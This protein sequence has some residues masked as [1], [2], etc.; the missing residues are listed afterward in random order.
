MHVTFLHV[1]TKHSECNNYVLWLT[2]EGGGG[3]VRRGGNLCGFED[4][5]IGWLC[6]LQ[7]RKQQER[8]KSLH[9]RELI[10]VSTEH[11]CKFGGKFEMTANR[12]VISSAANRQ[13]WELFSTGRALTH[14]GTILLDLCYVTAAA[15]W[16]HQTPATVTLHSVSACVWVPR[17]L[18]D[19]HGICR[20]AEWRW[21]QGCGP[22]LS[23][24]VKLPTHMHTLVLPLL[25]T[26]TY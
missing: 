7:I 17:Q 3:R 24:W 10:G 4:R 21:H 18:Q 11:L 8:K 19:N 23:R 5:Y 1:F 20:D 6:A 14:R 22:G 9:H 12:S 25:N 15:T 26:W 16:Q 2:D 13:N